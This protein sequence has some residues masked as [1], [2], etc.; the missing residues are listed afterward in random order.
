ML[1]RKQNENN[2]TS[3]I[4]DNNNSSADKHSLINEH[5]ERSEQPEKDIGS[6]PIGTEEVTG[7]MKYDLKHTLRTLHNKIGNSTVTMNKIEGVPPW[8]SQNAL[9]EELENNLTEAYH[10]VDESKSG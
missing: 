10:N 9:E 8:I 5:T 3:H 4:F 1:T 7:D 6:T 2:T